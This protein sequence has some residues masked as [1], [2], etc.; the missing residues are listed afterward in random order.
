MMTNLSNEWHV[1]LYALKADKFQFEPSDKS[2]MYGTCC[3]YHAVQMEI[4]KLW[5]HVAFCCHHW[6][7][8]SSESHSCIKTITPSCVQHS[9]PS[10]MR[11]GGGYDIVWNWI[12][13]LKDISHP[14]SV[15]S[16]TN[17]SRP[18]ILNEL[19][20]A[21]R[22]RILSVSFLLMCRHGG[23]CI[24]FLSVHVKCKTS[25]RPFVS[26][27]ERKCHCAINIEHLQSCQ[28]AGQ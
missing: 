19:R 25:N 22:K 21:R 8:M 3:A 26:V 4:I 6:L 11:R 9:K 18:I 12:S 14:Q 2:H 13:S 10:Q 17:L 20:W 7:Q 23:R 1:Y 15:S 28:D 5:L 16:C 27:R 24:Y